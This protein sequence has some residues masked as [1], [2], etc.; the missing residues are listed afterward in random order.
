MTQRRHILVVDDEPEMREA[1]AE[2]L[3]LRGFR[4]SQAANGDEMKAVMRSD[5]AEVVLLDLTLPGENGVDLTRH[6]KSQSDV[7]IIMVTAHGEP[8]DRVLG[9]ETGADDYVVKPF[10]FRELMARINSVLRRRGSS[11]TPASGNTEAVTSRMGD[12]TF[13][14]RSRTL[15]K[16]DGTVAE[17]STGEIDLLEIFAE[18]PDRP[19]SRDEL[20]ERS[21]HR[22][23]EPFDRAIDVRITR[24]RKKIEPDPS[25]P[26]V[27]RT[28]RGIGYLYKSEPT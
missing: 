10:N 27:I 3:V 1:I 14:R 8:E 9:L 24:L 23:W 26:R 13:D 11:G 20:L 4:V 28:V 6:L 5:A 16:I 18:N 15:T 22:N 2:Y 21:S 7:G 19:I 12:W 17:F 25:K